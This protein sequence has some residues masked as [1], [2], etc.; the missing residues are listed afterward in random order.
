MLRM[1][2]FQVHLPTTAT[3]AVRLMTTLENAMYVAGGTDLLPNLKHALHSPDHLI[4]L[5]QVAEMKGVCQEEDGT[6]HI[7]AATTLTTIANDTNLQ[8]TLPGLVEAASS[9]AGPQHRNMGTIGGNVMLDTR[10]LFYNQTRH[11]RSSLGYCLKKDGDWCHV[12]GSKATC[13]AAHSADTPPILI[14]TNATLHFETSSGPV[15]IGIA[16]LY[17]Q[18]GR[19]LRNHSL[20]RSSLLTRI[21]IPPVAAGHRSTYRKVRS[22]DAVDFPQ[23]GLGVC[24]TFDGAI[25]TDLVGVISAVMPKPKPLR[26]LEAAIGTSLDDDTIA[27]IAEATFKQV[28]PQSS[29]H[30]SAAW[31]RHMA[32]VEMKR[33][34]QALRDQ[35]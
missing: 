13:V 18:D 6:L 12:I 14:A 5:A 19:Y 34:L 3:E 31:R 24:A 30:G 9:V 10:C 22:R 27:E 23:L 15:T 17:K 26:K 7:G 25:C 35:H 4:S 1:P 29:I 11:W 8:A 16:D 2:A 32:R 33:A 28:R 20:E 21:Q